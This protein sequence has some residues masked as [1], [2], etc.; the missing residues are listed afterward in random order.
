MVERQERKSRYFSV[1]GV[2]FILFCFWGV[3]LLCLLLLA[4]WLP[5]FV[6][7]HGGTAAMTGDMG[8]Q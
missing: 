5:C 1:P 7:F 8:G 2:V 3:V 6:F 4:V